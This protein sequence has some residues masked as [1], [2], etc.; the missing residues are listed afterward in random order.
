MA[1]LLSLKDQKGVFFEVS[2]SGDILWEYHIPFRGEIRKPNGDP[3]ELLP[4]PF[5]VFRATFIPADHPALV[6]RELKVLDPQ[7]EAFKMLP[8]PPNDEAKEK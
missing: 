3:T 2:P 7:P 4:I 5:W 6:G 1:T 8:P